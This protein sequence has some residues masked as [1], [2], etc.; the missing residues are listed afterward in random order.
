MSR[1]LG[2]TSIDVKH[3]FSVFSE[4]SSPLFYQTSHVVDQSDQVILVDDYRL[5]FH[6][7]FETGGIEAPVCFH[8]VQNL[9][10]VFK[11]D[12]LLISVFVLVARRPCSGGKVVSSTIN[13]SA[14]MKQDECAFHISFTARKLW[15]MA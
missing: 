14:S 5:L 1:L 13:F 3:Q 6:A 11:P 7:V 12:G 15:L 4:R 2:S 10:A 9:P 8:I